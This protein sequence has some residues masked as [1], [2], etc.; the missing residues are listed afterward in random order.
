MS[1]LRTLNSEQQKDAFLTTLA[2]VQ[3]EFQQKGIE[4]RIIGSLAS[5]AY[6]DPIPGAIA[7][8]NYN[9]AGAAT[10]DQRVPDI[11]LIVPRADLAGAR[12][13]RAHTLHADQPVKL[14]LANPTTDI[15]F[16]PD[17]EVSY[18]T[19]KHIALPVDNEL[20]RAETDLSL[21]GTPIQ[22]IPL[23]TLIHTYGTF[24]GHIRQKDMPTLKALI[25]QADTPFAPGMKVFH[26]FQKERR[27]TSPNEYMALLAAE[28]FESHVPRIVRNEMFRVA[29]VAATLMGKR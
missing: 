14:G 19:H 26:D 4:Y 23:E 5:H 18:L 25:K 24:G 3:A 29:L 7:P 20:L 10:A 17:E 8:L 13:I 22:T 11:D 27:K 21:E 28:A 12:E 9:R 6:L 2:D 16:R 15:D 1:R